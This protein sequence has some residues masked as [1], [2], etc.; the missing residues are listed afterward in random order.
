MRIVGER[1]YQQHER[2]DGDERENTHDEGLA[3]RSSADKERDAATRSRWRPGCATKEAS[4]RRKPRCAVRGEE[5]R[6]QNPG[7]ARGRLVPRPL[8]WLPSFA[9]SAGRAAA[10]DRASIAAGIEVDAVGSRLFKTRRLYR[11]GVELA[12]QG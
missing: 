9:S 11:P 4:G 5:Q 10:R 7:A 2:R 3:P 6:G 1:S 8:T 12:R